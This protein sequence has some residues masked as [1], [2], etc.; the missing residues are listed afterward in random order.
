MCSQAEAFALLSEEG[1]AKGVRRIVAVTRGEAV[2]AIEEAAR[3][4]HELAGIAA[5]SDE[6]LEK[7]CK[8]FKEV[9]DEGGR[10]PQGG[11]RARHRSTGASR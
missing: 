5:L 9:S 10:G 2:R 1:I 3:L 8:A 11:L 4:K 6:Q 7:A